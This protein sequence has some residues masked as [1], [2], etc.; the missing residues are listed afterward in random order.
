[1]PERAV[2]LALEALEEYPYT[3]QA[4]RALGEAV[5]NQRL[6]KILTHDAYIHT[7]EFSQDGTR[8]LS[9]GEDGTARVWDTTTGK[10]LLRL[11]AGAP[12]SASWSPD[13]LAILSVGNAGFSIQLW[14][15]STSPESDAITSELRFMQEC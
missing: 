15:V 9:A 6:E 5:L 3:W 7:L 1:M 13:E 10:E 14:D 11:S 8:L 12:Q 4:E 2:P